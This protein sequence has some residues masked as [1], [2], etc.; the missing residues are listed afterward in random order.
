V[1]LPNIFEK[2]NAPRTFRAGEM[3]FKA[4]EPAE[5]MFVVKAGKVDLI[6]DGKI[7]ETVGP[8]GFFGELAL[9]DQALRSA[10]AKAQSDCELAPIDEKQFLF[11][12]GE[13]PFFALTVL[14]EMAG[15]LRRKHD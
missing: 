15:R 7:I 2:R 14:R 1:K 4:G 3:I 5:H 11:M 9:V 13:T 10:D 8:D 12:V 6:K